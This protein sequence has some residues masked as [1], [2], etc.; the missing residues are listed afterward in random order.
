MAGH[1]GQIV[2]F[3]KRQPRHPFASDKPPSTAVVVPRKSASLEQEGTTWT[4][5][6]AA[7]VGGGLLAGF[8]AG[9]WTPPLSG[10]TSKQHQPQQGEL[11]YHVPGQEPH[12]AHK[13]QWLQGD[14][15]FCSEMQRKRRMRKLGYSAL[16]LELCPIFL[17]TIIGAASLV[18][19]MIRVKLGA[20]ALVK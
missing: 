9:A 20:L 4:F 5:L 10:V 14:A 19:R 6:G 15:G 3:H 2:Q 12:W 17:A 1:D 7:V 8:V 18:T 13:G 11:S 16:G